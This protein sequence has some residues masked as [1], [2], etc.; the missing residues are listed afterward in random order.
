MDLSTGAHVRIG[1]L[2]LVMTHGWIAGGIILGMLNTS[3]HRMACLTH[4][5]CGGILETQC[6]TDAT[7]V[8]H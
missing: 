1:G 8:R 5:V 2:L 7:V 3:S 4:D 6:Y